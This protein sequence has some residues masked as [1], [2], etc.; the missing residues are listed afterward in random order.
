[1]YTVML[2]EV[3]VKCHVR[4][5]LINTIKKYAVTLKIPHQFFLFIVKICVY[6]FDHKGALMLQFELSRKSSLRKKS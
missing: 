3:I 2:P 1:M 5:F 4:L 6:E